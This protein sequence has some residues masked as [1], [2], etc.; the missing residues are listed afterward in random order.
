MD[1]ATKKKAK[2]SFH[3]DSVWTS[4]LVVLVDIGF[5]QN[6]VN[7][8]FSKYFECKCSFTGCYQDLYQSLTTSSVFGSTS[9]HWSFGSCADSFGH[10]A[11]MLD[12][13]NYSSI[14]V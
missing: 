14:Q 2:S 7:F 8:V 4:V 3:S 13:T 1:T 11:S 10:L 9:T 6:P 12:Q 5:Q